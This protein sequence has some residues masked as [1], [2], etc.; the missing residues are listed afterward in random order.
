MNDVDVN[1]KHNI[2]TFW[3][4]NSES[5]TDSSE[6][7]LHHDEKSGKLSYHKLKQKIN[8]KY[9]INIVYKYSTTLDV[10]TRYIQCYQVLYSEASYYCNWK[11]NMIMLPCMFLSTSCSVMSPFKFNKIRETLL[12]S[13]LNGIITFLLAIVNF[14]KLDANAE[15]HKISAYQYGKLKS[16]IE[17]NSGELLINENDPYLNNTY[18]IKNLIKQWEKQYVSIYESKTLFIKDKTSHYENLLN[19]KKMK[20]TEFIEKVE[21]IMISIKESLKNIE[22]NNHFTLPK[23][24]VK[25]Y[26]TIYN[27]NIF[28]YIK[29]IDTYKN[30]LFQDLCNVKNE[31][32]FYSQKLNNEKPLHNDDQNIENLKNRCKFLYNKKNILLRE[33][34]ELNK[35]YTLIDSMLQQ[36]LINIDL[37]TRYY[38][39]FYIQKIINCLFLFS[40]NKINVL[41][42]NYKNSTKVGLEDENGVFLLEKVL[43]T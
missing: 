22:D 13:I 6:E 27:M 19:K 18:H 35:G 26:A 8:K 25:K 20:E 38:Y 39:L 43:N 10:F 3:E 7:D 17:F 4:A 15:A 34:F 29:R 1:I 21:K 41:P 12:F 14:L 28:L 23:H 5:E 33:L 36:E 2:D 16:Q 30:I 31:I 37:Y 40:K 42:N 11:L 32:R 24:I 9:D